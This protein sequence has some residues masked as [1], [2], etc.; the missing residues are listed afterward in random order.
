M[1]QRTGHHGPKN[2]NRRE[3]HAINS[4]P[5]G[6]TIGRRGRS[7]NDAAQ[8]VFGLGGL[9]PLRCG[10]VGR[11]GPHRAR[12]RGQ[13]D[14]KSYR[15][16]FHGVLGPRTEGCDGTQT[17]PE[18]LTRVHEIRENVPERQACI[19]ADSL[20]TSRSYSEPDP[21]PSEI[22]NCWDLLEA[23]LYSRGLRGPIAALAVGARC[24][25]WVGLPRIFATGLCSPRPALFNGTGNVLPL[26]RRRFRFCSLSG[27]SPRTS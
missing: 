9:S 19:G 25:L 4:V 11:P 13:C 14:Q 10:E 20:F 12:W 5:N 3:D 16:R 27:R 6:S 22:R 18:E 24:R 26:L 7:D 17:G 23:N 2:R 8:I 21:A 15:D 1:R